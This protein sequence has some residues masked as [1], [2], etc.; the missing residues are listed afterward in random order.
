VQ[1]VEVVQ[2]IPAQSVQYQEVV[3]VCRFVKS[4]LALLQPQVLLDALGRTERPRRTHKQRNA[5]VAGK[6]FFGWF[7]VVLER[8]FP[9]CG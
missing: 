4:P 2:T 1:P 3:D 9:G 6:H 8:Q 5:R 7:H